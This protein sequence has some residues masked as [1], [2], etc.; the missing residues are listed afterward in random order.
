MTDVPMEFPGGTDWQQ[1]MG[2]R[3]FDRRI[4]LLSGT[5]DDES[6]NRAGL[7]LMTLDATGDEAVALHVDSGDGT[8]DAALALMDVIDL[9]GVPV[10]A[11]ATGQAAGPALGVM[12]VCHHRTVAP[13]TRLR[14]YE[15]PL[16]VQGNAAQLQQWV[17]IHR[18]RWDIF[19]SRVATAAGRP[20]DEVRADAET[21]RFFTA[22]EAVAYG[23]ADEVAT[24][25]ARVYRMPPR[26][27]GFGRL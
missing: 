5:L 24:P 20:L 27:M 17:A 18:E 22:A 6:A 13:H 9:L 12:A 10:H 14:L 2:S 4:V 16:E 15:P 3:L 21:G 1:V 7:E 26:P 19:C 8:V 11:A 23:L 25:D